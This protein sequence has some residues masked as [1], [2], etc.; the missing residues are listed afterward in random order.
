[1]LQWFGTFYSDVFLVKL[2]NRSVTAGMIIVVLIA[3]RVLLRR[4]PKIFSYALWGIVLF[5]LLCPIS[6]SSGF[7]AFGLLSEPVEKA[8][9]V[10]LAVYDG[11]ADVPTL[12]RNGAET[13]M[14]VQKRGSVSQKTETAMP[15]VT[16]SRTG[17]N[18]AN[19][20]KTKLSKKE[21]R[22]LGALY[23]VW[24]MGV[25]L[26]LCVNMFS[27]IQLRKK[28]RASLQIRNRVFLCDEIAVPFCLGIFR[29]QIY[30]PSSLTPQEREYIILHEKHHIKRL[31]HI[32]KLAAF[33]AL[34]LHWFNPLVWIAYI[35][36]G[37]DMEMSCDEAVLKQMD[38]D[39]R[40]EYSASL[41]HMATG[42]Q[43][44]AGGGLSFGE[45][46]PK[47]RIKN[48][49]RYRKP[50][51]LLMGAVLL[52][53]ASLAVCLLTDPEEKQPD[54]VNETV[55]SEKQEKTEPDAEE[56]TETDAQSELD[57]QTILAE[58]KGAA[59]IRN[60]GD[61]S[62][63][64][65][66]DAANTLWGE[67][68]NNY[69]QLAQNTQDY[70]FYNDPVKIAEHVIHVD[71]SQKGF[72]VFLTE[73]HK[74]YG[75][76]NAGGG[77]LQQYDSFDWEMY[78][79]GEHYAISTPYLLMEDVTYAVCGRDDVVALKEDG[80]VWTW[81]T[82]YINGGYQSSDV[83]FIE[84]PKQI[85]KNAVVITGGWF[86]H[87]ALLLDGTVWTWGYNS[88]GN[89]GIVDRTVIGEPVCVAENA[90]MVWT[91]DLGLDPTYETIAEYEGFYPMQ[92][93]N[94]VIQ[95]ADGSLWACGENIGTEIHE[96][97]GA[98]GRYEAVSSAVFQRIDSM[99]YFLLNSEK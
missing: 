77:A 60:A 66:I 83:Y 46:N 48:I 12:D 7:S 51:F 72:M 28:T 32:I 20:W 24:G 54:P 86:H 69:G 47:Q 25:L 97:Q 38:R 30:L 43:I 18:A 27:M 87:A 74:L 42:R 17:Q 10:Q 6:I 3:V 79:D 34:C 62:N 91:G 21:N 76:G 22:I 53:C 4:A 94:T 40:S 70:G 67:G 19:S 50:S 59:Y 55:V 68:G 95:K 41:L 5:R 31:D 73:D 90:V 49:M 61:A 2:F 15:E 96:I 98:E 56:K 82:V 75:V 33:L 45:G 8:E 80:T 58:S 64:Y 92:Y 78:L 1:M 57:A 29:P 16:E 23:L 99:E 63:L 26:L 11:I 35:L 36:A 52:V 89:C 37:N 39:I 71:F 88:A 9:Q 84:K 93:N 44:I 13:D 14:D 81:G 65:K 85:L